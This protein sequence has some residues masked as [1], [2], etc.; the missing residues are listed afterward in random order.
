V[1]K[2]PGAASTVAVAKELGLDA[3]A[4]QLLAGLFRSEDRRRERRA[5]ADR[6]LPN[7]KVSNWVEIV[8]FD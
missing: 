5:Q 8:A 1:S 6:A 2:P 3:K 7:R 4:V